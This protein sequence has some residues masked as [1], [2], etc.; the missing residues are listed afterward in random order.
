MIDLCLCTH[1]PEPRL[2]A[3]VIRALAAQS[4]G[5]GAFRVLLLD[6]ATRVPLS[7]ALLAPLGAAGIEARLVREPAPGLVQARLRCIEETAAPWLLFVDD[8]TV[9]APDFIAEGIAFAAARP[10]VG[11]FGGKLLLPEEVRAPAWA[12]PFFSFLAL[13]DDGDEVIAGSSDD[14]GLWEPPGAGLFVRR[15][16]AEEFRR[17]FGGDPRIRALGRRGRRGLSSG[18]DALLVRQARRLDLV[19]AYVPALVLHH[20]LRPGRFRLRYLLPFMAAHG[21]SVVQTELLTKGR[22]EVPAYYLGPIRI[23]KTI[24][25]E[26]RRRRRQSWRF[27]LGKM[28]FHLGARRAYLELSRT[29]PAADR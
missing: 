26:W 15:E 8:D 3:R 11:A 1:D 5:G 29:P 14:W 23:Y 12:R 24:H 17:R 19:T 27:F 25:G 21:R 9:L 7:S 18:E 16:V 22:V 13:R 4:A 6:S 28:A 2:L 10:D 20:H